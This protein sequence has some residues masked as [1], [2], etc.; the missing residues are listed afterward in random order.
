MTPTASSTGR[1]MNCSTVSGAAS[2]YSVWMVRVGYE[3][4]GSRSTGRF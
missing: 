3:R 1:V 4:S 2:G